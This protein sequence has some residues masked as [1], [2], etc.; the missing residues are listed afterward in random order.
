MKLKER[1]KTWF[2]YELYYFISIFLQSY[3]LSKQKN[4]FTDFTI[5]TEVNSTPSEKQP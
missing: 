3:I 1:K 5:V 4:V 2:N